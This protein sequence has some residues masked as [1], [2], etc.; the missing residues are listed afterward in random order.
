MRHQRRGFSFQSDSR[1]HLLLFGCQ[2][3]YQR[4]IGKAMLGKNA[5]NRKSIPAKDSLL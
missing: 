1:E 2:L 3:V 4:L 5:I